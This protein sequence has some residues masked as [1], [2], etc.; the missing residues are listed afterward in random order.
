MSKLAFLVRFLGLFALMLAAWEASP[1]SIAFERALLAAASV[2]GPALH[3][4]VLVPSAN[5][6]APRWVFAS[7]SVE[8]KI[9]FDALAVGIVPLL[10]LVGATPGLGRW[11][12]MRIALW[13]AALFFLVD[14]VIVVLFPLLVHYDNPITDVG[15]T[16]LG[17][18]GFVGA[19][20]IIWFALTH[21]Q[22]R[23]W[24]PSFGRRAALTEP[25]NREEVHP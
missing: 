16:F 5:G 17:M 3:G 12:R 2:L 13:A 9:Q 4:W 8:L 10:S 20:V 19:P 21:R 18:I 24:L 25:G 14:L 11:P 15:G 22:L 7:S 1:A 23:H 6:A